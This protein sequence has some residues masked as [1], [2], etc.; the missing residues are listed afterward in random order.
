MLP[1][2]TLYCISGH[3]KRYR[4]VLISSL[5]FILQAN[6]QVNPHKHKTHSNN[7]NLERCYS[8]RYF[9]PPGQHSIRH[10]C[11][12]SPCTNNRQCCSVELTTGHTQLIWVPE[13]YFQLQPG[14]HVL[15]TDKDWVSR[16][17]VF[18]FSTGL[19]NYNSHTIHFTYWKCAVQRFL[20]QS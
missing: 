1:P 8:S 10:G 11:P 9:K 3:G 12:R 13:A 14:R 7:A 4:G 20:V 17:H 5:N 2:T 15:F 6:T 19:L 16:W 18:M